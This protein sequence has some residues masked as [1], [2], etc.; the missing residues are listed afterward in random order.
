[1]GLECDLGDDLRTGNCGSTYMNQG[2]Y[3]RTGPVVRPRSSRAADSSCCLQSVWHCSCGHCTARRMP[4]AA[5][6]RRRET[7]SCNFAAY[8]AFNWGH[9]GRP[10]SL[11]AIRVNSGID[12]PLVVK[13]FATQTW[14]STHWLLEPISFLSFTFIDSATWPRRETRRT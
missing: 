1:M 10:R 11:L 6:D 14:R 2:R 9:V 7:Q 4:R 12:R 8:S 5:H 13:L 3:R